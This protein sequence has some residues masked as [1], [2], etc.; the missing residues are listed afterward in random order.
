MV[1]CAVLNV[2]ECLGIFRNGL[3]T[4][5]VDREETQLDDSMMHTIQFK[6]SETEVERYGNRINSV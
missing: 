5:D 2:N 6:T 1:T 3:W 4:S